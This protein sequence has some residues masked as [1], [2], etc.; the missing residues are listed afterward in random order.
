MTWLTFDAAS[1]PSDLT[2][3]TQRPRCN[4]C[5]ALGPIAPVGDAGDVRPG[6]EAAELEGWTFPIVGRA[7][8]E[9]CRGCSAGLPMSQLELS[10]ERRC[11]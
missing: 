11:A 9:R 4:T 10:F 6:I 7:M 5:R 8:D 2:Q 3:L 1:D